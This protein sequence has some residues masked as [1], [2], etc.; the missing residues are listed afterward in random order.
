MVEISP[1]T[2]SDHENKDVCT[3]HANIMKQLF[4]NTSAGLAMMNSVENEL[5]R[6][7]KEK[8]MKEKEI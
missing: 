2:R 6:R 7:M 4:E 3:E 8:A 1:A 5:F